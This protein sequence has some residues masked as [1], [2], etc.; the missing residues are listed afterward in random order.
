MIGSLTPRTLHVD[1]V[2]LCLFKTFK[3]KKAIDCFLKVTFCQFYVRD[4][5]TLYQTNKPCPKLVMLTTLDPFL[6]K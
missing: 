1:L 4:S 3:L 6:D 2:L 5:S